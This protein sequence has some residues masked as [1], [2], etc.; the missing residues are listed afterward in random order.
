MFPSE[1]VAP[2]RAPGVY[3]V[4]HP[5]STNAQI[6]AL[7]KQVELLVKA[8]TR[9][10]HVV[11]SSPTCENCGANHAIESCMYMGFPEEQVNFIQNGSRNFNPYS[12]TYNP[13][14]R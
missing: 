9:G 12:Q 3:E 8:R 6:A 13:G 10:A 11:M 4:D 14:W 1:R 5:T 2:P 7:T